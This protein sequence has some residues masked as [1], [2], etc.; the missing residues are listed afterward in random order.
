MIDAAKFFSFGDFELDAER[1]LLLKQGKSVALNAKA[2][3]LLLI[4]VQHRGHVLGKDELME[5]IWAGQFVEE[6]NLAVQVSAL[7]KIFGERKD[8]HRFIVTV[9]GPAIRFATRYRAYLLRYG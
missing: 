1:R 7:R 5:K 4:L 9:L 2:F 3:N 6:N 8:E